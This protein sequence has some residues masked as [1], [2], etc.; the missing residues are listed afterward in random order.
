MHQIA[1]FNKIFSGGHA[2]E[3]PSKAR[4][5]YFAPTLSPPYV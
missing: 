2:L 5:V 1:P 4:D 3:P